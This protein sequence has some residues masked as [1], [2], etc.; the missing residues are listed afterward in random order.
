MCSF[1]FIWSFCTCPFACASS[2]SNLRIT[3]QTQGTWTKNCKETALQG[4]WQKCF[5]GHHVHKPSVR[6]ASFL[7]NKTRDSSKIR[8][9]VMFQAKCIEKMAKDESV[10]KHHDVLIA[11]TKCLGKVVMP[12]RSRVHMSLL[13][14]K[15]SKYI[16]NVHTQSQSTFRDSCKVCYCI[17]CISN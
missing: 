10:A 15:K 9:Q 5:V 1:S 4:R 17:L 7:V 16:D 2:R 12:D 8:T 13:A 11:H 3:A 6:H 14:Y